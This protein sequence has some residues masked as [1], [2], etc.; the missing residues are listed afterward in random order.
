MIVARC[1]RLGGERGGRGGDPRPRTWLA[2][3][4]S[5][6]RP[7][8]SRDLAIGAERHPVAAAVGVR[9]SARFEWRCSVARW[10]IHPVLRP[11]RDRGA[12]TGITATSVNA[13]PAEAVKAEVRDPR[14]PRPGART[15]PR[16]TGGRSISHDATGRGMTLC[17]TLRAALG[18]VQGSEI[19]ARASA[20]VREWKGA[21]LPSPLASHSLN[22]VAREP[23][24][25][26][27]SWRKWHGEL[28]AQRPHLP[29]KSRFP[30]VAR[31]RARPG[32]HRLD[33]PRR[34]RRAGTAPASR[35]PVTARMT[36]MSLRSHLGPID[37]E[38]WQCGM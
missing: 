10:S 35:D 38:W 17:G 14:R 3:A 30:A 13:S 6:A 37:G 26:C 23:R 8:K 24:R 25:R 9:R 28:G 4:T 20:S 34:T 11:E 16:A 18:Q 31:P 12:S 19:I 29:S 36:P 5:V 21:G 27:A 22:C 15:C 2:C 7:D 33:F 1:N 32:F